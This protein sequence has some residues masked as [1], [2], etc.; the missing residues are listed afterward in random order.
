VNKAF[1]MPEFWWVILPVLINIALAVA[2]VYLAWW[3]W[4]WRQ[5]L[6]ILRAQLEHWHDQLRLGANPALIQPTQD[7]LVHLKKNYGR[8]SQQLQRGGQ[9]LAWVDLAWRL[10]QGW[11]RSTRARAKGTHRRHHRG[12]EKR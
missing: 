1:S 9:I 4:R 5:A 7:K 11:R 8:V 3:L 6:V 12:H 10:G 2:S